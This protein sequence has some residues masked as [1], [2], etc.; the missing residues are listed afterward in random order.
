MVWAESHPL[1]FDEWAK[2]KIG[3]QE[4]W[5]LRQQAL[6]GARGEMKVDYPET[7]KRLHARAVELGVPLP[8]I[9]ARLL[10]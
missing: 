3:E 5:R 8:K 9:P 10:A 2:E 6:A 4:W 7:L 1:E